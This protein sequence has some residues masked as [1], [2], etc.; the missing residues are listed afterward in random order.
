[1]KIDGMLG[2]IN[3][4]CLGYTNNIDKHTNRFSISLYKDISKRNVYNLDK[5]YGNIYYEALCNAYD[6]I[7]D[8]EKIK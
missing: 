7:L 5:F 4:L 2:K 3:S 8:K 6:F 1:M